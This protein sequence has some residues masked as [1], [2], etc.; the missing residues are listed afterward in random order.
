VAG[1]LFTPGLAGFFPTRLFAV[2]VP[3]LGLIFTGPIWVDTACWLAGR[4]GL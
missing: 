2:R 1:A 3:V 4:V